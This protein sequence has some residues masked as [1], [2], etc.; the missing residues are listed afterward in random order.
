MT[1]FDNV[2]SP[3]T[4]IVAVL[5]V[6]RR[7]DTALTVFGNQLVK[8]DA[9]KIAVLMVVL[10]NGGSR[11]TETGPTQK[12]WLTTRTMAK[13]VEAVMEQRWLHPFGVV[14]RWCQDH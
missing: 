9:D 6:Q 13:R 5:M 8:T 7:L 1:A 10:E 14:A 2:R 3:G 11:R 12:K 4:E